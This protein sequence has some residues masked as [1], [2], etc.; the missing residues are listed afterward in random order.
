MSLRHANGS[1]LSALG[2]GVPSR[3]DTDISG[4]LDAGEDEKTEPRFELP[5]DADFARAVIVGRSNP[6]PLSVAVA[7]ALMEIR[8]A[9][10]RRRGIE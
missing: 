7:R 2:P 6:E 4:L 8:L 10:F 5:T 9:A 1:I 3:R